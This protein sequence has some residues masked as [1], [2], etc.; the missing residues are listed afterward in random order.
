MLA[1]T[2]IALYILQSDENDEYVLKKGSRIKD[3]VQGSLLF[4]QFKL[5]ITDIFD[6][7]SHMQQEAL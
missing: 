7:L 2:P 1:Q 3:D 4:I 6:G 5:G